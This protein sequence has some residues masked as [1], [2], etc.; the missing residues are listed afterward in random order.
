MALI[1]RTKW[2]MTAIKAQS[3][4][5][6][7]LENIF[8]A[9]KKTKLSEET[10]ECFSNNQKLALFWRVKETKCFLFS[11]KRSIFTSPKI[12]YFPG[13]QPSSH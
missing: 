4:Q 8:D 10:A 7:L 9:E 1:E 12:R 5:E 11:D 6:R 2:E 3:F 13:C